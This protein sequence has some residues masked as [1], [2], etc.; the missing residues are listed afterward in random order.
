MIVQEVDLFRRIPSHVIDEIAA[1]A[2]EVKGPAGTVLF[3][4]GNAADKLYI[5][6][7][8]RVDLTVGSQG[9]QRTITFPVDREQSVFGWSALVEPRQY[10]ATA[11]CAT[12]AELLSIDGDR[13]LRLFAKHPQEGLIVMQ[14][15][16]G[17][18]AQRLLASYQA[19][20]GG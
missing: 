7:T 3:R 20:T 9:S 12:D 1:L 4:Q 5:L 8:G 11:T 10:T 13:L 19:L 16:A 15:L 17:L 14:R 18:V 2:Q 6:V